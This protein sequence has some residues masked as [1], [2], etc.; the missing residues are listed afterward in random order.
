M[1]RLFSVVVF[2]S[3]SLILYTDLSP[4]AISCGVF[5]LGSAQSVVECETS[6]VFIIC[7]TVQNA[8]L[9]LSQ[10]TKERIDK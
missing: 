8:V 10:E 3:V 9:I 4:D 2:S 5:L 1:V 7:Q 6:H